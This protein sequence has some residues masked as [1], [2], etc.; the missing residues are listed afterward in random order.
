MATTSSPYGLRPVNLLGGRHFAGATR[1]Y[2]IGSGYATAI[3]YGDPVILAAG[4]SGTGGLINRFNATTTATTVTASGTFLGV[5]L[6]C[7]YT[8]STLG[9]TFKQNYTGSITAT[10]I[11]AFVADDPDQLFMVQGDDAIARNLQGANAS[12]IQTVAGST[13]NYKVSGVGLD[14]SSAAATNTLPLR[15]VDFVSGPT[16]ALGDAYT[17]VIVRFNNHF[18]RTSTGNAIA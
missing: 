17:D 11:M 18:H 2:S 6:G 16:S 1:Q 5:F 8:D 14:V 3:Q 7:Q 4:A 15:I 12:L 9:L 13:G 10:D